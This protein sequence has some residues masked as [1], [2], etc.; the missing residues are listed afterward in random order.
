[1]WSVCSFL[2]FLI[3]FLIQ[4][5]Y[6]KPG[7][8]EFPVVELLRIRSYPTE[9]FEYWYSIGKSAI[10]RALS[11]PDNSF[12]GD[13]YT[14]SYIGKNGQS[15]LQAWILDHDTTSRLLQWEAISEYYIQPHLFRPRSHPNT[16]LLDCFLARENMNNAR[17][18]YVKL[19]TF[20]SKHAPVKT[21]ESMNCV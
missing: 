1:M 5:S 14:H 13:I 16:N 4:N 18:T 3:D 12:A 10:T 20:N 17:P 15:V 6:P 21:G 8:A 19:A 11:I 2:P 7:T 9:P